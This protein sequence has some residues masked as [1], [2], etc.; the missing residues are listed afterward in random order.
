M[1]NYCIVKKIRHA[2]VK[3]AEYVCTEKSKSSIR[4]R[5]KKQIIKQLKYATSIFTT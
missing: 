5:A 1:K 2:I 4:F 3:K